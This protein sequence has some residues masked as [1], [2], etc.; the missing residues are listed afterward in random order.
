MFA[1][2]W[3]ILL[4]YVVSGLINEQCCYL[5]QEWGSSS[6]YKYID[7]FKMGVDMSWTHISEDTNRKEQSLKLLDKMLDTTGFQKFITQD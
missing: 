5:L 3:W 6:P 4:E 7:S 2:F 1:S